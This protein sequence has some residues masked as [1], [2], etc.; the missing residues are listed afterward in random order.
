[1]YVGKGRG[2]REQGIGRRL[3]IPLGLNVYCGKSRHGEMPAA[4]LRSLYKIVQQ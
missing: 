4:A 1:M 2:R 3:I